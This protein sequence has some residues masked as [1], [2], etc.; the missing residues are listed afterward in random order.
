MDGNTDDILLCKQVHNLHFS[1]CHTLLN[2]Q[3]SVY[4]L[5]LIKIVL[6]DRGINS[7]F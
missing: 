6:L 1:I 5:S 4:I 3:I 2:L 7:Y